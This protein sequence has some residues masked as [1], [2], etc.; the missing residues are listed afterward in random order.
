MQK[1]WISAGVLGTLAMILAAPSASAA[2]FTDVE[3]HWAEA[4]I[5]EMTAAGHIQGYGDGTFGPDDKISRAEASAMLTRGFD[6]N[7]DSETALQ[8][9]D[10]ETDHPFIHYISAVT[11]AGLFEGYEDNLFKPENSITRAES[12]A[13][14]E[15]EVGFDPQ[16]TASFADAVG[17]WAQD[18]I[19]NLAGSGIINGY[20]SDTFAPNDA[21]TRAEFATLLS[22]TLHYMDHGAPAPPEEDNDE[23]EPTDEQIA[24]QGVAIGETTSTLTA[25]LGTPER[26]TPA[27]QGFDWH[28]YHDSYEDFVS[29]AV[30]E[31]EVIGFFTLHTS[32]ENPAGLEKGMSCS[33]ADTAVDELSENVS[34][35]LG[36][37]EHIPDE[38]VLVHALVL[39][40]DFDAPFPDQDETL[41]ASS[42]EQMFDY[43]NA[44]RAYHG[45]ET[46]TS[47]DEIAAVAYAHSLDMAEN[48]YFNHNSLDGRT[49]ADRFN[50]ANI[51][52]YSYGGENISGGYQYVHDSHRGL[53]NSPGHRANILRDNFDALGVGISYANGNPR[54]TQKFGRE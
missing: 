5:Q 9:A 47:S 13:T 37:D 39:D 3:N 31:N 52:D 25:T 40:Q 29:F 42:A 20:D 34:I 15:R 43:V 48:N 53:M 36:Y 7:G 2:P 21:V 49:P 28:T 8:F 23:R 44:E 11:E 6:L 26:V 12:A 4:E 32:F 33:E 27:R 16:E 17:H 18:T 19:E 45:L 41:A 38:D 22:D 24:A 50:E 46:L 10:L 1:H 51:S 54:Y 14:L 30:Y 35:D